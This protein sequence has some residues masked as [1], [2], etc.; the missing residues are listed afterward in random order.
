MKYPLGAVFLPARGA[1]WRVHPTGH[2]Q[3]VCA[4]P[5]YQKTH[6]NEFP[7]PVGVAAG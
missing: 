2:G 3:S 5:T 1:N 4:G 6:P 7:D